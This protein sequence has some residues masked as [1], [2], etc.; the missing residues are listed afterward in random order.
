VLQQ[1]AQICLAQQTA[2]WLPTTTT[3]SLVGPSGPA[4]A[5]PE[6][7]LVPREIVGGHTLI[8]IV[9]GVILNNTSTVLL[10][11]VLLGIMLLLQEPSKQHE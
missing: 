8:V 3:Y 5:A 11:N 10:T 2:R 4:R 7:L 6:S 1:L 9:V